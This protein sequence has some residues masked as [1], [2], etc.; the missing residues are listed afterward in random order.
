MH[1]QVF[2]KEALVS[3]FVFTYDCVKVISFGRIW[4]YI[5]LSIAYTYMNLYL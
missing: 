3:D 4:S 1:V 5:V 2:S